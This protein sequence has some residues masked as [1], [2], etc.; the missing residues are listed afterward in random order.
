MN[1]DQF[2]S[3]WQHIKAFVQD[4]W[5]RLTDEDIRQINGRYD[6]FLSKVQQK[7]GYTREEIEEQV[8]SWRPNLRATEHEGARAN[9]EDA[10]ARSGHEGRSI[11]KWL[12]LAGI[13][14]LFLIGY[15]GTH[16]MRETTTTP[17]TGSQPFYTTAPADNE[18]DRTVVQD[19]RR[20]LVSNGFSVRDLDNVTITSANG[21]VTVTGTVENQQQKDLI[22]RALEGLGSV[23]RV[24][25]NL[26]VQ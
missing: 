15:L 9:R 14:L 12:L 8:Q 20:A 26:V 3:Q 17:N 24:N 21:V 2:E 18:T 7:Y 22:I 4:K 1:K 13:P 10:Y 16:D 5:S 6:Q 11:G 25:D 23:V 19:A